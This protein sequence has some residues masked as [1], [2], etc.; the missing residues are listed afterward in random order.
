VSTDSRRVRSAR[1]FIERQFMHRRDGL[2]AAGN[3][4]V[5]VSETH[6]T[7]REGHRV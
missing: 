6:G 7:R 5:D 4:R 3:I 2:D 1:V